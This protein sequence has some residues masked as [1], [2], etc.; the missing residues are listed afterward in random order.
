MRRVYN[1]FSGNNLYSI[2][3]IT[4]LLEKESQTELGDFFA[5][6]V[7][8]SKVIPIADYLKIAEIDS[9]PTEKNLGLIYVS[10]PTAKE[11]RIT[12]YMFGKLN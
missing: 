2:A 4:S 6:Y 3:D 7:I 5:E 8:G 11:L 9:K 10:K 1:S 12:K